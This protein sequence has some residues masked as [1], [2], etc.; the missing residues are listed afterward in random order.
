MRKCFACDRKLGRNPAL[1]DTRDGQIVNVGSECFKLIKIAGEVGY[2]PPQGGPRL[3]LLTENTPLTGIKDIDSV[4]LAIRFQRG[5]IS[6]HE[7]L[8]ERRRIG[9]L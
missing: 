4:L 5:N 2:Q 1:V 7:Y 8:S 9:D 6:Q 3:F